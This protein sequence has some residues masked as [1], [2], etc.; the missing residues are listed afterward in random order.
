HTI[1]TGEGGG[2]RGVAG[3]APLIESPRSGRT[4]TRQIPRHC[5]ISDARAW[6]ANVMSLDLTL[7]CSR[8]APL[9]P[10]DVHRAD[11]RRRSLAAF[12]PHLIISGASSGRLVTT[13]AVSAPHPKPR[14]RLS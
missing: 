12:P 14:C 13:V 10:Q 6:N 7:G 3:K 9:R 1:R 8:S 4:S 5:W 2:H 11:C